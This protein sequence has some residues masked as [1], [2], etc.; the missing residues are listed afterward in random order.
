M[1]ESE[2]STDLGRSLASDFLEAADPAEYLRRIGKDPYPWQVYILEQ[3]QA[4]TVRVWLDGARQSGKSTLTAGLPAFVSKTERALSLIYAA[5]E[6]Q[7]KDD[8]DK[9]KEYIE[10][11]DTYPDLKLDSTEHIKLPNGSYIKA[12]T[13]T[14]K[15]K[16]GKSKPRLILFD[17]AAQV[18]D[19]LYRTVR[20][21]LTANPTCLV[22]A[23]STPWGKSGFFFRL[24]KN[25]R[26]LRVMVRAPWEVKGS[27][28]VS[29]EPEERFAKRMLAEGIHAFYSP[30]HTDRDFM[31]EELEEHGERWFRQ[32]YLCEFV[33]AE[34]NV[35]SYD[36]IAAMVAKQST[37]SVLEGAGLTTFAGR[38]LPR[39]K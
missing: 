33:E 30:R 31:Q 14:A 22:I 28:V 34:D 25:P 19:D 26:W 10:A 13:S 29:A 12:N 21:M 1:L 3:I 38:A 23:L 5:S 20:P 9:V 36:D 11:D 35:F 24:S 39:G 17:E 4:G 15:T 8:I 6:D 27:R 7:A 16:R 32:E 37:G 2:S 18:G